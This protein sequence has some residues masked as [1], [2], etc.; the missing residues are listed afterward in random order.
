[1]SGGIPVS[2]TNNGV[3][4]SPTDGGI[5]AILLLHRVLRILVH[6]IVSSDANVVFNGDERQITVSGSYVDTVTFTVAD[7]LITEIV[8]S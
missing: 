1:M 4:V 5:V 7:G 2:L 8:L 3:P 6:A